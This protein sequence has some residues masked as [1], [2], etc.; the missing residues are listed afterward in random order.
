[1]SHI[2]R[3]I[4]ALARCCFQFR[5]EQLEPHGLKGPHASTLLAVCNHPGISQDALAQRIFLN[6]SN[7]ARQ[8]AVLE[9]S[10][11]LERRP[12]PADKRAVQMYPTEQG[13][14]LKPLIRSVFGEWERQL[15]QGLSEEEI[16]TLTALLTR[17]KENAMIWMEET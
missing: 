12:D 13:L 9:E 16:E 4:T 1:M 14:A 2:A 10:G 15:T 7:V 8:V 3:N 5:N 17:M 6:K 11:L